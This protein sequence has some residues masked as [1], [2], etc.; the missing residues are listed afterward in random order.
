MNGADRSVSLDPAV[1]SA[2]AGVAGQGR[3]LVSWK[4]VEYLG[5]VVFSIFV[6]RGM[7]PDLYGQFAVVLAV[8]GVLTVVGDLGGLAVF[9]RFLPEYQLGGKWMRAQGLFGQLFTVRTILSGVFAVAL[10]IVLPRLLPT[11]T[12][13]AVV[14]AGIALAA[15]TVAS[16]CY[17]AFFGLNQISRWR[18]QDTLTRIVLVAVMA[19]LVAWKSLDRAVLAMGV[20]QMGF[21]IAGLAWTRREFPVRLTRVSRAFLGVQLRFGLLFF[22]ANVLF[23]MMWRSGELMVL[24]L[25]GRTT[26]VAFFNVAN[27]MAMAYASLIGQLTAMML[28]TLTTL[29]L[30]G[31]SAEIDDLV[32]RVLKYLIILSFGVLYLVLG[33]GPWAVRVALGESFLPV[34]RN[35]SILAFGFPLL[36]FAGLG[37]TLAVLRSDPKKAVRM[38]AAALLTFLIG[39]A[40][41][42]RRGG[43]YGASMAEVLAIVAASVVVHREFA[44]HR[45]YAVARVG[46]LILSGLLATSVFALPLRSGLVMWALATALFAILLAGT[47]VLS[48][49]ELRGLRRPGRH[50]AD[51]ISAQGGPG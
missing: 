43:A 50:A 28:P 45:A 4:V 26:E 15:G 6:P 16:T 33:A 5:L 47:G 2:S 40:L 18:V 38:S 29:S 7:G 30:T 24:L 8:V 22:A 9:G 32:G 19:L 36:A 10:A 13:F 17:Q 41:L 11:I 25:S 34:A 46:R 35:L 37:V 1:P 42:T 27:A 51:A 3:A 23:V 48:P 20:T 14:T 31:R 49:Q 12:W 21:L 44:L 39:S